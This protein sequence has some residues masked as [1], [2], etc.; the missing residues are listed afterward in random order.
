MPMNPIKLLVPILLLAQGVFAQ[1][2]T[3]TVDRRTELLG[4]VFR[5]AGSSEYSS[6]AL[7]KYSADIDEHFAN[8]RKHE[9]VQMA[10]LLRQRCGIG[11]DAVMSLAV[12]IEI[13]DGLRLCDDVSR[14]SLDHRWTLP[15]A[16]RFVRLLD[17]F[18]TKSDF[19]IFF[20]NHEAF[21]RTAQQNLMR[22]LM[23][24]DAAW[25]KQFFGTDNGLSFKI[26]I[27]LTHS[28]S[29]GEHL[30]KRTGN[31]TIYAIVGTQ[32]TDS[33]KNP[34][35]KPAT[36][37]VVIH[38]F[39]HSFCNPI[40]DEHYSAM[41]SKAQ[42]FFRIHSKLLCSRDFCSDKIMLNE[43]FVRACVIRYYRSIGAPA[44]KIDRMIAMERNSGFLWIDNL[45]TQIN[46][47]EQDR[48]SFPT[49]SSYMPHVVSSFNQLSARSIN[50]SIM[51]KSSEV[52]SSS[53]VNRARNVDPGTEQIV[54]TFS[55]PMNTN[56]FGLSSSTNRKGVMPRV[57]GKKMYW[58]ENNPAQLVIPV[59]L[60]PNTRY[61]MEF[62]A[63]LFLNKDLAPL[64][65]TFSLTFK[66][67]R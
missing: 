41:M 21:Y 66:T 15:D 11:Y 59:K 48:I 34:I 43:T 7:E 58:D 52:I 56:A 64:S 27:C 28:G 5:L 22:L 23:R 6:N 14:S 50:D 42:E 55:T 26:I 3:P 45:M 8:F 29:F 19:D 33:L 17:D 65:K 37:G 39:C 44:E 35:Y 51:A 18:Y 54:L 38:E 13:G 24:V 1:H 25:F 46:L 10:K 30:I 12:N 20:T 31:S 40:V 32:S 60:E 67:A 16:R 57:A 61:S 53:I 36:L 4:I 47:Y 9:V 2:F 49:L 63:H 62:P